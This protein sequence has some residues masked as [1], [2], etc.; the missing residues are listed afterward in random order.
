MQMC[1]SMSVV[2]HILLSAGTVSYT[3][4]FTHLL[5]DI[6]V[7]NDAILNGI[8]SLEV[9]HTFISLSLIAYFYT[10]RVWLEFER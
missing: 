5:H 3:S 2:V 9:E 8:D 7:G 1:M 6:P 4:W 10:C